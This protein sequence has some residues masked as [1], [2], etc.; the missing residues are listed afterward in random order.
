MEVTSESVEETMN[1]MLS[2][3]Y[4]TVAEEPEVEENSVDEAEVVDT[5]AE[6]AAE[7][8]EDTDPQVEE[9]EEVET[10][11]T[12]DG[13]EV[14]NTENESED[15]EVNTQVDEDSS[16]KEEPNE[17]ETE[18]EEADTEGNADVAEPETTDEIDYKKFYE[19]VANAKFIANGVEV[20]G[21]KDPADLIRSQQALHGLS[22]KMK[23][24][25]EY[26]RFIKPLQERGM[27]ENPDQFNLAMSLMDKDPEALKKYMVDNEID[28]VMLE[29]DEV[30]Y[31]NRNKLASDSDLQIDEIMDSAD[32]LGVKDKLT[33]VLTKDWD[34]ES[35]QGFMG[36]GAI[37]A[38][39]MRDLSNGTYD[40]VNSKIKTLEHRD[41]YG[42]FKS[43]SSVDKYR[44]AVREL[45][46]EAEL[47]TKAE[48]QKQEA[49]QAKIKAQ[50]EKESAEK[51]AKAKERI[52]K[53]K[54]EAAYK[55]KVAAEEK[56][57]SEERNKAASVSKTT[58]S[59]TKEKKVNALELKGDDF[60]EHFNKL[61]LS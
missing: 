48:L 37:R 26:R 14:E 22:E 7:T 11:P 12:D 25:K 32:M 34:D 52:A 24:L 61:L 58:T 59:T 60:R 53:E 4:S 27:L 21:F 56:K 23:V 46:K 30:K 17:G 55:A 44:T 35:F 29:L 33:S 50:A 3:N 43:M 49:E 40:I 9:E 2:G 8:N 5:N 41:V 42:K 39:L 36:N 6:E 51:A 38:D 28:P 54:E 47:M 10:E 15:G 31:E 20:E 19:E 57:V 18:E 45:N 1:A 16:N 13:Q